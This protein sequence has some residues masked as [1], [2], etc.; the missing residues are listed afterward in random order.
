MIFILTNVCRWAIWDLVFFFL[1]FSSFIE[2]VVNEVAN[3]QF[4]INYLDDIL[5]M[6]SEASN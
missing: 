6:G 5:F 1:S 4:P 2:W 3:S